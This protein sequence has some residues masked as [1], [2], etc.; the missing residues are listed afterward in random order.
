MYQCFSKTADQCSQAMKQA[1]KEVFENNMLHHDTMKT[2]ARANLSNRECSV[3][4]VVYHILPEL[5]LRRIFPAKY[6][7][8]TNLPEERV[9]VLVPEKELSELPDNSPNIFKRSNID[10]FMERSSAT[11]CN[12]KYSVLNDFCCPE[13]LA[14]YTLENKPN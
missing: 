14:Y 9:Q 5:K 8:N 1:A 10:R 7:V 12:G 6:F 11:F 2:I 4:E 3:Q 13:F